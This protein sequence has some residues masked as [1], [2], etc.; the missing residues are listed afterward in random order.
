MT[1]ADVGLSTGDVDR[2]LEAVLAVASETS[3]PVVL[4]RLVRAACGLTGARYGALG[5]IGADGALSEFLHVGVDEDTVEA[6]GDPPKGHGILGLLIVDPRPLRLDRLGDHSESFGFPPGHPVM[7]SFLGVPIRVR[8]EVFGNLYLTEKQPAGPFTEHD[9]HLTMVLATVAGAVIE[10]A[11]RQALA[12]ELAVAEDR[13]RIARDLHDTVIQRLYAAGMG[14]QATLR[15]VEDPVVAERV[16]G[17]VDTLDDT[18]K[19]I[20]TVIFA[21]ANAART[22]RGLRSDVLE[23]AVESTTA[24]GFEPSVA[25][26][27]AVDSMVPEGIADHAIAVVREALSNVARHADA[28]RA[29]VLVEV[30]DESV[31]VTVRDDGRGPL[32]PSRRAGGGT[33]VRNLG[34]RA[35]ALGGELVLRPLEP[36]TE[37]V[38]RVPVDG[39]IDGG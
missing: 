30:G 14:L 16:T 19:E 34:N 25:F 15:R 7:D 39:G 9:E 22:G 32:E 2:L 17:V 31:T 24:L 18:I 1:G 36:G 35:K 37:L 6:I 8:G 3:L 11:R 23:V 28:S 20:R 13:E 12:R 27:G 21:V 33:G 38:W 4:R 10:A 5:V 29:Q 26:V